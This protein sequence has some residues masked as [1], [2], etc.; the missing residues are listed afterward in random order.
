MDVAVMCEQLI[1]AV[2]VTMD[3]ESSQIYRLEALKFFEEF[4]EKSPLCVPCSFQ[5]TDKAQP[6]VVRHFGL[7]IMEHVIKFRWN[8]MELHEKIQVKDYTMQLLSQGTQPILQE[9]S[10][11]KDVLSRVVVEMIKREWPQNW[12]NMLE[13]L[14]NL[15]NEGEA[16][17]ELVMLILL[18]LAEDVI[19]FQTL[20]PQRRRDIQQTLSQNMDSIFNFL[21]TILSYNID[22]YQS[23]KAGPQHGVKA[24]SHCRVAVATLNT[25][26]GYIDWV[27]LVFIT[28]SNFSLLKNLCLLLSEPELQLEAVECL[29][30]AIS[31]KGRVEDRKPFMLLFDDFAIN[32]ILSAA[33]S[34]DGL[35]SPETQPVEVVE[36][37][38]VF[39]K[40][41]CQVLCALGNQLVSLVGSEAKVDVPS[42]L[43]KYLEALLAFTT[44]SSMFLR[45]CTVP[46]WASIFR[47]EPLIQDPIIVEMSIKYLRTCISNLAK[48]G[49]PSKNDHP[50]CQ[51]SQVDFD[52]DEDFQPFF[53]SFRACVGQSVR[54][55]CRIVPLQAFQMVAVWLQIQL[56]NSNVASRREGMPAPGL[57]WEALTIFM[58]CAVP[59]VLKTLEEENLPIDESME[60]LQ[61][62]LNFNSKDTL[63]VSCLLTNVSNLFPFVQYRLQYLPQVLSKLFETVTFEQVVDIKVPRTRAVNSVRRHASCS[64]IKI[65]RDFPQ[66]ILPCF[67]LFYTHVK[68]MFSSGVSLTFM[69]KSALIESLV[70]ISNEFKDYEKQK[71]FI[72]ELLASMMAQWTS[73]A[74]KQVLSNPVLFLTFVGADQ[75]VVEQRRE[76]DEVGL[77]RGI[78]GFSLNAM[79]AVCKRV[80]W[81]A[82]PHVAEAGGYLL[83]HSPS[84]N[85]IYRNPCAAQFLA[86]LPNLL[87]FIRTQNSLFAPENRARLS[88]TFTR[89]YDLMDGEKNTLLGLANPSMQDSF[90][91]SPFKSSLERMQGFFSQIFENCYH[92][93][94]NGGLSL[95]QEFY[96]VNRLAED[97][98][99][100]AF[101]SLDHVPDHRLRPFFRLFMRQMVLSCPAEY[102]DCLLCPLLGPLFNFILQNLNM[103]WKII[104][105]RA[106]INGEEEEEETVV[107]QDSHVTQEM[108]EEHLVRIVTREVLDFLTISCI[109]RK[110]PEAHGNKEDN[111]EDDVMMDA[112]TQASST[113]GAGPGSEELTELGKTLVKHENIYMT[114][115]SLTFTSLSWKD[116]AYCHRTAS[117]ICWTIL[118]PAVGLNLLPEAVSWIFVSVLKGLQMHGQ[119]EVCN[120]SLSLLAMQIYD[121]FRPRYAELRTV[122]NQ[123]PNVDREGLDIYDR[124]L[125]EPTNAQKVTEKKRKD[126]FRRFLV[127]TVEK[128]LCQ[129]FRKEVHIR[130]LPSLYKKPKADKDVVSSDETAG[131]TALF[132]PQENAL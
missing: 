46:T 55:A 90:D 96:S 98:S 2:N 47:H 80:R 86:F 93:L 33:Q 18:R 11:I 22:I 120:S 5:L 100:S 129:Q 44:H 17:T 67:D 64:L 119:H 40:R 43:S 29:L 14:E 74:T 56:G 111:E 85:P 39:L 49:F 128:A 52:S 9:E 76:V 101:F 95:Q 68:E 83:G 70:L 28:S 73:D 126:Q 37:H 63:V 1:K 25:L 36:R 124:R 38:Y 27:P 20:P 99:A 122:M 19:T 123:I 125:L 58:E 21:M 13:E 54:W 31:R 75:V 66:M 57:E 26:A 110:L 92:I 87:V 105:Q 114:L 23:L 113:A 118:R 107:C 59:Q 106:C 78:L 16:Q 6:P 89:A 34:A 10:Y 77:N 79:L 4:K 116:G 69:E 62:M 94:G 102:Y 72:D 117:M 127:G 108:L 12:P 35:A 131:L 3:P 53:N 24:R 8:D 88:E 15:S 81:P 132:D 48:T 112:S 91:T 65:C 115:L 71:A 103:K 32:H 84:G 121:N 45:S 51:Y 41:L 60:L 97:I 130:N 50:S 82:D 30:I 104:H 109:S 7:Q 61:A 42:N